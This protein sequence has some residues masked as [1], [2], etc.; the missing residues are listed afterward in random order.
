[1]ASTTPDT[2]DNS[3]GESSFD[4]AFQADYDTSI[5]D[6]CLTDEISQHYTWETIGL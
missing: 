4:S 5:Y 3:P 1:M 2:D 6:H